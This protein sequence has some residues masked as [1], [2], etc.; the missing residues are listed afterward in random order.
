MAEATETTSAESNPK[1]RILN[2]GLIILIVLILGVPTLL[3]PFGKDQGEYA[4]IGAAFLNGE[5]VYKDIFNVKPPMT[6]WLHAAAITIFGPYMSAIRILDLLWQLGAALSIYGIAVKLWRRWGWGL[7]SAVF[8]TVAY[9]H[10]DFWHTAQSDG[11]INF[12]IAL[13]VLIVVRSLTNGKIIAWQWFAAGILLALAT[14]LKYPI[15]LMLPVLIFIYWIA[16]PKREKRPPLLLTAGFLLPLL[17]F[18]LSL[19][20]RGSLSTFLQ[21]QLGYIPEYNA[22]FVTAD[23]YLAFS[24]KIFSQVAGNQIY[25]QLFLGILA[26][27][28]L[29]MAV[30]RPKNRFLWLLPLWGLAALA[31]LIIQNKYYPYHALPLLAPLALMVTYFFQTVSAVLKSKR[32]W[33]RYL[34]VGSAIILIG[35]TMFSSRSPYS[36]G[37]FWERYQPLTSIAAGDMTLT[38]YYKQDIFGAYG[39][40]VFSS[41]ANLEVADYLFTHTKPDDE[42]FIWAFEP[43]IYFLSQRQTASR[44]IYNFPLYGRF[45]WPEF[46]QEVVSELTADPPQVILVANG[47]AQPWL[48]GTEIDSA[49]ALQEFPALNDFIAQQYRLETTIAQF[50]I[51]QKVKPAD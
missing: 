48:T 40:P 29:V 42:I 7:L 9:H 47:D 6:H 51:Y 24:W 43:A 44:F 38:D 46:R 11:F 35:L 17:L 41:R 32:P 31:H 22:G 39:W 12:P 30:D 26:L 49:A 14:L 34:V 10:T 4:Y 36:Y 8:F 19:V 21:I 28:F 15:G 16:S 45:A 13:S 50:S 20:L 27:T 23:N 1:T 37:S 18:F 3:Y 25:L 2:I 5:A 33:L